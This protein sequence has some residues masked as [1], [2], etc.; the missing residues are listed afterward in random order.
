VDKDFKIGSIICI[1]F[2]LI[3]ILC[4]PSIF[5]SA[6]KCTDLIVHQEFLQNLPT[7]RSSGATYTLSEKIAEMSELGF[8]DSK[9]LE[10]MSD[11][12]F[13]EAWDISYLFQAV[14]M[15]SAVISFLVILALKTCIILLGTGAYLFIDEA[16]AR[17]AVDKREESLKLEASKKG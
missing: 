10:E 1:V 3:V 13:A 7:Y 16:F 6:K 17:R 8:D 12:E 4:P 5:T 2:V 14:W 11:E 15:N 9:Y